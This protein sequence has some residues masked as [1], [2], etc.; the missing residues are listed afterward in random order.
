IDK[1]K[2]YQ[3]EVL[4]AF[5]IHASVPIIN[6]ESATL[7]PLQSFADLLT[8]SENKKTERP[9]IV[10]SWAPHVK[11][12]PQSVANS[13]LQWMDAT[14]YEVSIAHPEGMELSSQFTAN[15]P[16]FHNQSA[17]LS[18]A[19]FVYVKNWSS[20]ND[21]GKVSSDANWILTSEKMN[22]TNNAKLMHCLP[23]RRNVVIAGDAMDSRHSIIPQQAENRLFTAQAVLYE[24]L[25]GL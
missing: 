16:I 1:E 10:L 12:L 3:E 2:D 8:I 6:L 14:N 11:A 18:N 21:Y 25:K 20:F 15:F 17:A 4:N 19:D 9:K 24:I 22:L 7:H 23:V 13:F 5:L